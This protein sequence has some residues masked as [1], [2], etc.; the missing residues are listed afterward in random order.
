M[1]KKFISLII[2]LMLSLGSLVQAWDAGENDGDR[3]PGPHADDPTWTDSF[4]DMSHVYVPS[5]GLVG[6]EVSG[7]EVRLL[8]G[9]DEGWIASTVI[10]CPEGYKYDLVLLDAVLPGDSYVNISILNASKASSEEGFANETVP[11]FRNI[12][13]TDASVFSI[14]QFA[15]PRIR[16]QV[17]LVA[18]GT[19]RPRLLAWS[20]HYIVLGEWRDDFLGT[21][22]MDSHRG[23]NFTGGNLEVDLSR[24]GAGGDYDPYPPV[25]FPNTGST[26]DVFLPNDAHDGY[27]ARSTIAKTETTLG[28]TR[29]DLNSDGYID[30][31]LGR[32]RQITDTE[33]LI[34]WGT[35]NGTWT[36]DDMVSLNTEV[37]MDAAT[38][39]IDGDGEMDIAFACQGMIIPGQS[40]AY[41]NQGSGKFNT[42]PDIKFVNI[43][44]NNVDVGDLNSDGY[45]DIVYGVTSPIQADCYF[46]G[47]SGPDTT[48]DISL[49]KGAGSNTAI[50]EVLVWDVDKDG[51]Q[52]VLLAALDSYA[53]APIYLGSSTGP[54][55]TVDYQIPVKGTPMDVSVG[56]VNGDGFIDLV[57]TIADSTG[58]G[59]Q[60]Q[61]FEGTSEGWDKDHVHA[62]TGTLKPNPVAVVDVDRD[63]YADILTG[64]STTF[65][66]YFGGTKWPTSPG[67]SKTGISSPNDMTVAVPKDA[68]AVY[69]AQ[70]ITETISRSMDKKWD[71]L[72]LDGTFPEG[73][74]VTISI[75]DPTME[76]VEGY[77][78]LTDM[79]VDLSGIENWRSIHVQVDLWCQDN[80]TTPVLKELLVN[81]MDK[82]SWREQF[83]GPAKFEGHLGLG[84]TDYQLQRSV[85]GDLA[86]EL[87][88]AS[89]RSNKG[90][91]VPSLAF[92]D[93]GG[94]DFT[95]LD[96]IEFNTRG[97]SAI[98]ISDPDGDGY[99]DVLIATY[100]PSDATYAST[101][102]LFLSHPAGW[103]RTPYHSFP[104]TGA[105]DVVMTD[106]NGDGHDDVVFAQERDEDTYSVNST[107]FWGSASG[108]SATPDVE[109]ETTGASG[110]EAVDVD[111][112]G[113]LDLVFACY[114][115]TD[116][117]TDSMVFL[118]GSTGFD[119][120]NPSHLLGTVGA[121]GV[122]AGDLDGDG[123]VDLVFANSFTG[124]T[125]TVN[126]SIYWG[127][128]GGGF[129][130]TPTDLLTIG[131]MDVK[132][133]DLDG[134]AHLDIVFANSRNATASY[135]AKS[136]VYLNDGSG[137][138]GPSPDFRL[139]ATAANA[140]AVADLDGT[141]LKDLVFASH[142]NSTGY[143]VPSAIYLGGASQWA[144]SPDI[145]LSTLGAMD[146]MAIPLRHPDR[147]GYLSRPISPEDPRGTGSFHTL[148]YTAEIGASQSARIQLID[149]ETEEVLVE[150]QLASGT[151]TI[152]L[153]DAFRLREHPSV[154][155]VVTVEGLSDPG[156]F[157][158]DDLWMNW[159]KRVLEAPEVLDLGLSDTTVYRTETVE[160]WVNATDEY[161]LP[162]ELTVRA[163]H[164]LVG[165]SEWKSHM[166]AP[167]VFSDGLWR[168]DVTPVKYEKLGEYRFRV[169][170]TDLD[171]DH[172]GYVELPATLEV[173]PNLPTEPQLVRATSGDGHVR[174]DWRA[175]L[176]EG[177]EPLTGYRIYRGLSEDAVSAYQT[178]DIFTISYVDESV[179]NGQTYYYA[180][181]AL[182]DLGDGVLSPVVNA[183]PM[184]A[185]GAPLNLAAEPGD[186]QVTLSWEAPE[187]DGGSPIEGYFLY[188][189][190][191]EASVL[192]FTQVEEATY[193]DTGLMNGETYYYKVS[194]FNSVGEGDLSS[195]LVATPMTL[196][197]APGDLV[198]E[199]SV[200]SLEIRWTRPV[201]TGGSAIIMY[202]LYRGMD[203]STM[204]LL[205]ELSPTITLHVDSDVVGGQSYY[206]KVTAVT[207]A[208]EGPS[209]DVVSGMPLGPPGA[210]G[211][212]EAVAGDGEVTLTW[213]EPENTGGLLILG[214]V[215][216]RGTSE[217][218]LVELVRPGIM[219]SYTDV[220]VENGKT[221]YYAV[222]AYNDQ[223]DGPR[224]EA[225]EATPT[226]VATAPGVPVSL[227]AE[228]KGDKV[229]L[230]WFAPDSDG[231]SPI[232]GYILLRGTSPDD[233]QVLEELGSILTYTDKGLERGKT[234][235]YGIIA[236]NAVGQG[237]PTAA[238]K[239]KVSEAEEDAGVSMVPIA[240]A[241]LAVVVI[242]L[243][244]LL[245]ARRRG[246]A[247]EGE[248]VTEHIEETYVDEGTKD[249]GTKDEG[250]YD[251][252]AYDE[253]AYDEGTYDEGAREE[254]AQEEPIQ[255][256]EIEIEFREA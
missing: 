235:Y 244:A 7:G 54:D 43:M 141:G 168:A 180:V 162:G 19:D 228:V 4:D 79:N 176:D 30:L 215:I 142:I 130:S 26:V 44:A 62:I 75:L 191:S 22:K 72:L 108:W 3:G 93:A 96:P 55:T 39:D 237:E 164:Q 103:Y 218:D 1:G 181:Q 95:S 45:D 77:Q 91:D 133:S 194:A 242:V 253:G 150:R 169:N 134:D 78:E 199:A 63:G 187:D 158:L 184:G 255:P 16:I 25:V 146:V 210:P 85:A 243:L 182:S 124:S 189:G 61:I 83:Y 21:G 140:V 24:G 239:A 248:A 245:L 127:K 202:R 51:H 196:P 102:P 98:A 207:K 231:G 213:A 223:G 221:Y 144:S 126:S 205:E 192:M 32:G 68:A 249:E 110:V 17:N 200:G 109:F 123:R 226:L 238:A 240:L 230:T 86:P 241:I 152:D 80:T 179:T 10:T 128:A 89:L 31:V 59:N 214:Y 143:R 20:L 101:S 167:M 37:A 35:S 87:L 36:T 28:L 11:G 233:L 204:E 246:P 42:N 5:G 111:G 232:T 99:E 170:V 129:E 6:V 211:D 198:I 34:I 71:I 106:L 160:L 14:G 90:Y 212:L 157:A 136:Y 197:D 82:M 84:V 217:T 76:P 251:E 227:F 139:P 203:P 183:T 38:G 104:T 115:D 172:S 120:A 225:V 118:Q 60:I 175:P 92:L 112:D 23:L 201:E 88:F 166:L 105:R 107:L 8:P 40:E 132:V 195:V 65:K 125:Y 138:F 149:S 156:A 100:G 171:G 66:V 67:I 145:E 131:A 58:T 15:Y 224:S 216:L 48:A 137:G 222:I 153:R 174:L 250:T 193:T 74:Q 52:D 73:T 56:D 33:S 46:G 190:M 2:V 69:S 9:Q 135:E 94:L 208:G 252:G 49:F 50:N 29:G 81:W 27:A 12:T 114:M 219:L 41:L 163:E 64:D 236:V 220:H 18:S 229:V 173:L 178:V 161:D 155:V 148:R 116:A 53:N 256:S 185:P 209:S 119:G 159:T 186:G 70:F 254:E 177:D 206:Y 47:A 97:A 151:Q 113:R 234:Y 57:Y 117:E 154:R 188:R 165:E 247:A 13:A 122:A 121:R 147:G